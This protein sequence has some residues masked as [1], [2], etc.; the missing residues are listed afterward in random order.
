MDESDAAL[1]DLPRALSLGYSGTSHKNCKGIVKSLANA[2]L[3]QGRTSSMGRPLIQSA[4]DLA[5]VGP[6]AL[7]Q[8]LAVVAMLGLS[9]VERNGHHY[10]RGLSMYPGSV[11]Q[12]VLANHAD[13]YCPH[14]A[15]FATLKICEGKLNLKSVNAAPFGCGIDLNVTQFPTLKT[16]IMSGGMGML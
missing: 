8:D 9:H 6:V 13:L 12:Q 15:G 14:E 10:F 11:Q 1:E 7:L 2:A 4:E 3:I 5:N 16:W